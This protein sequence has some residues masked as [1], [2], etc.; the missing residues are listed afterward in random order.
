MAA[1]ATA[2]AA[3][4]SLIAGHGQQRLV[5]ERKTTHNGLKEWSLETARKKKT[6]PRRMLQQ[7][8]A[9]H[10]FF[11]SSPSPGGGKNSSSSS[12]SR[13]PAMREEDAATLQEMTKLSDELFLLK[14]V[15]KQEGGDRGIGL[16][17]RNRV[18]ILYNR[19]TLLKQSA[20][21]SVAAGG[22][23]IP[24]QLTA[25]LRALQRELGSVENIV[26]LAMEA[27]PVT[28]FSA[29][30][31]NS[32]LQKQ[33]E[34]EDDNDDD[35]DLQN[36]LREEE[37]EVQNRRP[38]ALNL[39]LPQENEDT[40]RVALKEQEQK[41]MQ[42]E[43][44]IRESSVV[45]EEPAANVPPNPPTYTMSSPAAKVSVQHFLPQLLLSSHLHKMPAQCFC[46]PLLW[47]FQGN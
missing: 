14:G 12:S 17:M 21:R 27:G 18:D 28:T 5:T 11:S 4:P 44:L 15:L 22:G 19:A 26:R 46:H 38:K 20:D 16:D 3:A 7:C 39:L 40:P 1:A 32:R 41:G 31:L 34:E 37:E 13:P 23:R 8:R 25:S 33:E 29:P 6:N 35:N 10:G 30:K 9:Q 2:A 43:A 42:F 45:E 36:Q 24:V 47:D